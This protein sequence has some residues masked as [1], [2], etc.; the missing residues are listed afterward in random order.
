MRI[1]VCG[2]TTLEDA[3]AAVEAGADAI[4]L[5]FVPGTPR[6]LE[7]GTAKQIADAIRGR[8]VRVG[9]FRDAPIERVRDAVDAIG[10][11]LAQLHGDES[12]AYARELG[13]PVLK[14][15]PADATLEA[16]SAEFPD[17][18]EL[19][20]DH[21][22]GGGSGTPWDFTLARRLTAAGRRVWIA[23]GLSPENV[24]EAVRTARPH[25]VDASSALESE[26]GRKDPRRVR[27]FISAARGAVAAGGRPDASGYFGRFGGRYV[28]EI[29]M[30][31]LEELTGAYD[32]LRED[33][34]FW[35]ELRRERADYPT[36]PAGRRR[37]TLPSA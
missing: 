25:G 28:P 6:A 9:V 20:L 36:T 19:L 14:A 31:A 27:A 32:V 16:R 2:L 30:P 8:A 21:P 3:V 11:D 13:I 15:L 7:D 18:V 29:L 37:S 24:A 12:P 10:L 26:P 5:N 34:E 23:G 35:E 4:G 17:E 1:K 22:A 33:A